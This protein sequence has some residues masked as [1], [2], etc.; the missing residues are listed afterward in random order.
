M[1]HKVCSVEGCETQ[2]ARRGLCSKHVR[3]A[4]AGQIPLP[5]PIKPRRGAEE[6]CTADSC[7]DVTEAKGLCSK[8]YQRFRKGYLSDAEAAARVFRATPS[9]C[10]IDGCDD[11]LRARGYCSNHWY[12]WRHGLPMDQ[13]VRIKRSPDVVRYRDANGQKHC[14]RCDEWRPEAK[15]GK[16]HRTPDGLNSVCAVCIKKVNRRGKLKLQYGLTL[17]AADAIRDRQNGVCAI[18]EA[19]LSNGYHID[20]DHACCP[21]SGTCGHCV[22]GVLCSACNT[23]LGTFRDSPELLSAAITYLL[24]T[25]LKLKSTA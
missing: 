12:R 13:A 23:G 1:S 24:S 16:N 9:N 19:D 21:G 25:T 6:F 14:H 11:P 15:F 8:H 4:S 2:S 7:N 3:Q 17:E 18:C 22:R 10:S 5:P 20:H